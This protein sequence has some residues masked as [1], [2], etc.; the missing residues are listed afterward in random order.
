VSSSSLS[1]LRTAS[2]AQRWLLVEALLR[3]AVGRAATVAIPFRRTA[4][5]LGLDDGESMAVVG[6]DQAQEAARV[7]WA[8]RVAAT[9]TPW[10]STC[11]AQAL[12]ATSMLRHRGIPATLFLGVAKDPS[13]PPGMAAHAW[14]RCGDSII[15]GADERDRFTQ[16]GAFST[17]R[18]SAS[19]ESLS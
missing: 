4:K 17:H 15:T 1:K 6:V 10:Q 9:R 19:A 13:S 7:G 11:L 3:L 12:A 5:I 18:R 2:P 14:V 16:V 8:L